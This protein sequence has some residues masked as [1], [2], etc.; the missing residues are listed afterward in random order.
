MGPP[1]TLTT[2][3]V[4]LTIAGSDSGGG[5]GIQADLACFVALGVHGTSAVTALTAQ[6]T[7]GIS[8]IQRVEPAFVA[9]QIRQVCGDFAPAA[10]KTG[11][12]AGPET[13]EAVAAAVAD[14]G[15]LNLVVD[16]VLVSTSGTPMLEPG[17][18][19]AMAGSLLPLA[20]IVTPNLAEA[21]ALLGAEVCT[22]AQMWEAAA[23]VHELGPAWV[24]VKGGH[25]TGPATDVLFDGRSITELE[26]ERIDT[27][28]AHGTGCVLSAAITAYLSRGFPVPEAVGLAK[29][30][31]TG[32]LRHGRKVGAGGGCVDPAWNL[33]NLL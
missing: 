18:L 1:Q 21:G 8:G 15:I 17:G 5:A 13:I 20:R 12:L 22:L 11:M 28:H 9:E 14:C 30:H 2:P 24:L 16:P 26:G 3:P 10:A 33:R 25:L 19:A 7:R 29:A 6:N 27:P 31:V 23:A 4:A 32:A